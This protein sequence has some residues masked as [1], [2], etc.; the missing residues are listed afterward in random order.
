MAGRPS[1]CQDG[2][3]A[4]KRIGRLWTGPPLALQIVALL[5]GGLVVAQLVTLLLTLLLPPAPAP[6]YG[7]DDIASA[8]ADRRGDDHRGLQR[9][10]QPGPPA[11]SGP[12]WLISEKSR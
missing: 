2:V 7:L 10:V 11:I 6:L 4:K 9:I 1:S 12:G 8:L 5:L 3:M